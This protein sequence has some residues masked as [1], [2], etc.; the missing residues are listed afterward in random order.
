M[1]G[2]AT[3]L[4]DMQLSQLYMNDDFLGEGDFVDDDGNYREFVLTIE[5]LTEEPIQLPGRSAKEP[6]KV[7]AFVGAHKR[8]VLNK[9]NAVAIKSWHGKQVADWYGKQ[10]TVFYN[11]HVKFGPDT[12]GGV[13]IKAK[14]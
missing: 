5:K 1:S 3:D 14:K 9:T 2:N 11:P 13:R 12:V 4:K 6:K 8:L 10:V 7:L